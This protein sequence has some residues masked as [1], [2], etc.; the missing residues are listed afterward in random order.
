MK[1][2][3]HGGAE[4]V[5][6]ANYMVE[7]GKT[8]ILVDCGLFQ[9][10]RYAERQNFEPFPYDPR[11]I[12]AIFITHAHIDHIGRLP[13]LYKQGFHGTIYSTPPTKDFAELLLLDSEHILSEEAKHAK[14]ESPYDTQDVQE[15]MKLWKKRQYHE[16]IQVRS[17]E[18][19]FINAGHVLGSSSVLVHAEGKKVLFS[20]DLGN[21]DA[22]FIT[23]KEYPKDVDYAL[24]ESVYGGRIHEE[25][26]ERKSKMEALVE[27]TVKAGGVLM[28]PA[29]ALERT[30]QLLYEFNDLVENDKIPD[31]PIFLDSP[32]AI[33]LT[34]IY[35]KYSK[36]PVY[37]QGKAIELIKGGD[38][39]FDFPGLQM[40]L[41]TLQS[42]QIAHVVPPKVVIAG[43][44]MSNGGRII[45]HE[46][47]Y[48]SDPK[49][50]ILFIGYQASG[51]LGRRIL[52][53]VEKVKIL[54]EEVP[55]RCRKETIQGY[56]AHADQD[57]LVNWLSHLKNAKKVFVTQG[58]PEEAEALA[59]RARTELGIE[60]SV[61]K[62][63]DVQEL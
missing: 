22:P 50:S 46:K 42:K 51:S 44:G 6:G 32:L 28:M 18:A 5:T 43:A 54:R 11:D 9:G 2:T 58:E 3:F 63:R 27:E 15:V 56:S 47:A 20:G 21:I 40:T 26:E 35:Q 31:I 19:E 12:E 10:S 57:E 59:E 4:F 25:M 23:G 29:F 24:V 17:F 13:M 16:K 1:L 33:K 39:I 62:Q 37:F 36:D 45:H 49:S 14:K 60:I 34:A 38:A 7:V 48:L 8:K 41:T 52:D 30:Q 61:P 53:G 55:V